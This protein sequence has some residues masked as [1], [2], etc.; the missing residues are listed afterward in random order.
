MGEFLTLSTLFEFSKL[1][2]IGG[3][4]ESGRRG[5]EGKRKKRERGEGVFSFC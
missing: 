1:H 5:R 4:K 2:A 3:E